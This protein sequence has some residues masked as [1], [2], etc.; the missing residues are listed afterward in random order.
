MIARMYDTDF[1]TSDFVYKTKNNQ[2]RALYS[3]GRRKNRGVSTREEI[4][5]VFY[6]REKK[7]R[8]EPQ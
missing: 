2:L 8:H 1:F 4:A 7:S 5:G 6:S 3:V